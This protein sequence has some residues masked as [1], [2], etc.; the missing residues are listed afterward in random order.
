MGVVIQIGELEINDEDLFSLLGQ[1][2]ILP[3]LAKEI[4]IDNAIA[5]I[6]CTPEEEAIARQ[7]F[8][9]QY[10]ISNDAQVKQWLKY[11]GM[12]PPQLDKFILR[13][14]KVEKYK[15][16]TWGDQVESYFLQNK[17]QLD[18]VVYSLIR[19]KDAGVAQELY[20]RI[21]EGETT[22]AELAKE[23]SEGAEAETGGLIGPVELNVPHPRIS[24]MLSTAQRGQLI[25]PT[26]V[27]EW[28][29]VL[30]LEKYLSAQ[31]DDIMRQRIINDLFQAWLNSQLQQKVSFRSILY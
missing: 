1:Y 18:R 23:Y 17:R 16:K 22:F 11:H 3:Q 31:L 20:F 25:P 14:L 10:Q 24:Q 13:E 12:T 26:R 29:I 9:Q 5:D 28:W 27:G 15:Q 6:A 8:S 2:R 4:V 19:S 21:Q 7:R 30:R